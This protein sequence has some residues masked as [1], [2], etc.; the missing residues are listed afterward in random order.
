M[1]VGYT[2]AVVLS[3]RYEWITY[4]YRTLV[5]GAAILP[6]LN[7]LELVLPATTIEATLGMPWSWIPL[8]RISGTLLVVCL[9]TL[10]APTRLRRGVFALLTIGATSHYMLD[11]M[12]YK[13]SGLFGPFLWPV[14]DYRF[15]IDGIYLSSDRWPALVMLTVA[16]AVWYI[17]R[18]HSPN[19]T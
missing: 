1:L 6:D 10:L 11:L 4:P 19:N 18:R 8:H 17:D 15:A 7:R 16:V 9:G 3:W 14:T 13:P 2:L 5:M 12:L